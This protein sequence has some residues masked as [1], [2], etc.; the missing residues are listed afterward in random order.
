MSAHVLAPYK[1]FA[2]WKKEHKH[3]KVPDAPA[4]CKSRFE[5]YWYKYLAS[6]YCV[7]DSCITVD[8][9]RNGFT[10]NGYTTIRDVSTRKT[11]QIPQYSYNAFTSITKTVQYKRF[12]TNF[13]TALLAICSFR[14]P[15]PNTDIFICI[16]CLD[17]VVC[18]EYEPADVCT[19][20]HMFPTSAMH[21]S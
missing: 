2:K 7:M 13:T 20:L 8:S 4:V 12:T 3:N 10:F 6:V 1:P 19:T 17:V 16:A 21:C 18:S 11:K 5:G 14:Q 15:S 9:H